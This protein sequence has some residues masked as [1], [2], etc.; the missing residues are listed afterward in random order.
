MVPAMVPV[1]GVPPEFPTRREAKGLAAIKQFTVQFPPTVKL[2]PKNPPPVT[3]RAIAEVDIAIPTDIPFS[4]VDKELL[5][6][7]GARISTS[8]DPVASICMLV[9]APGSSTPVLN[10]MGCAEF[11]QIFKPAPPPQQIFALSAIAGLPEVVL[12][13][14]CT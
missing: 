1:E 6:F 13:A 5:T 9:R 3:D 8:R 4:N 14:K 7:N 12:R 2:Q 11:V 10:T